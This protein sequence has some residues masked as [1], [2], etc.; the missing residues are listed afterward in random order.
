VFIRE[1][2]WFAFGLSDINQHLEQAW[3]QAAPI[4]FKKGK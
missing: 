1:N 2:P 3:P 4:A